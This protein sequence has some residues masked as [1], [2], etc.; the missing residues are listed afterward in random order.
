MLKEPLKTKL[1]NLERDLM[2]FENVE[3]LK[4]VSRSYSR[5]KKL[6]EMCLE[7]ER[8]LRE[9]EEWKELSEDEEVQDELRRI[10][11]KLDD[12]VSEWFTL[13]LKSEDSRGSVVMEI[14]SGTGGDEAALFAA[15]LFR[16][17]SRYAERKGWKIEVVDFNKT[18]L[19][20][21]KEI[22]F[23]VRGK[24]V[25]EFLKYEAGVHRVQRIPITES[26][27]RIHTSTATVAVLPE[28]GES[29]MIINPKD[30]KI[31]TFR[32]SGHGGQYVNKTES[33]VRITHVPTGIVVS[34][35]T[36]R[37]QH[38]NKEIAMSILRSRLY[39]L[40]REKMES[41]RA[42]MRRKQIGSG[43]RSEKIRTYNFPQNRITDHRIDYTTYRLHEVLDGDLDEIITRLMM[44][45]IKDKMSGGDIFEY[46]ARE[47]KGVIR[48]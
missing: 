18:D 31:E 32:A 35:Q 34:I 41:T 22:V 43:D 9:R 14:R 13:I 2:N 5:M 36:E 27:G 8:L 47:H 16:M 23:F 33:A 28:I 40:E 21:F 19:G 44:K 25:Y 3:K 6:Y 48:L 20:G 12:L 1:R 38:R 26:G 39:Q 10:D 45:E 24:W 42:S 29:D 7:I 11:R 15:D 37:S 46:R 30:L 17:Y 4:E